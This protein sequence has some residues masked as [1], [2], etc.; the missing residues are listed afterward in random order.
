MPKAHDIHRG[1]QAA[2]NRPRVTR[3][4]SCPAEGSPRARLR[5][6]ESESERPARKTN[7]GAQRWVIHRVANCLGSI[8]VP[9]V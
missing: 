9:G 1:S 5:S 8:G 7:V 3:K 6:A 2:M 4:R